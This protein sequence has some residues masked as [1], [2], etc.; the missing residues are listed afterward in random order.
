S[1]MAGITTMTQDLVHPW[2]PSS[3]GIFKG[4]YVTDPAPVSDTV[5]VVSRAKD[6]AQDYGLYTMR[7]DGADLTPL[8]DLPG[9]SEL[10]AK[11]IRPRS[12]PPVISDRVTRMAGPLP[13][14]VGGPYAPGERFTFRA[15][16]VYFNAAVDTDIR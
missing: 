9:T 3:Y 8:L 2:D 14:P 7:A 6:V 5:L 12:L 13:P 15:L 11:P 16:N 10:R 4:E 1:P